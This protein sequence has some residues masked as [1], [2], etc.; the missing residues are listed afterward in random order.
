MVSADHQVGVVFNGC[1]YNFRALR[2]ELERRGNRF[3]SD[4]D[5]EVLLCGYR[6]WG[7]DTLVSRL[8]GMF[9]FAIWDDPRRTLLLVRDR[10]GVKPLVFCMERGE[11][12][13]ASTITALRAAGFGGDIDPLAVLEFLEFGFVTERRA[14]FENIQKLPPATIAEW[15]DGSLAAR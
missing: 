12:A 10:L 7:I 5:A 2:C 4:C 3:H 8:R 13:F 1:I 11:I 6:E 15:R 9:S 14:I